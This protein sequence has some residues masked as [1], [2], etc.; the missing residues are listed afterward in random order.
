MTILGIEPTSGSAPAGP[1]SQDT[2][3]EMG[4]VTFPV[5]PAG[6]TYKWLPKGMARRYAACRL[7]VLD[8]ALDAEAAQPPLPAAR[9][10]AWSRLALILPYLLLHE[11]PRTIPTAPSASAGDR[12]GA[13]KVLQRRLVLAER[14]DFSSLLHEAV[15]N[16]SAAHLREVSAPLRDRSRPEVLAQAAARADDGCLRTAARLL[17]GDSVLPTSVATA[18]KVQ[19][20]YCTTESESLPH[21][22]RGAVTCVTPQQT[23][24]RVRNARGSAHP[25]PGGERNS[26]LHALLASPHAGKTLARWANAW[27]H[28]EASAAVRAP[29]LH[30]GLIPLDKGEGKARPIV[31]QEALLKVATGTVVDTCSQELRAAAGDWQHGVYNAGGAVQLV[32]ELRA[33][34]A[35]RPDQVMTGIDCRNAFGEVARR[36]ACRVAAQHCPTFARLLHNL[37]DGV[38]QVIHIPDGPGSTRPIL[39]HDGFVQGG[40]EAA[41]GFALSLRDAVDRFREAAVAAHRPCRIWA[42]MDDLYVQCAVEDWEPLMASLWDHL[43]TVNLQC[44]PTKSHCYVPAWTPAHASAMASE[45]SKYAALSAAGLPTLGTAAGGDYALFLGSDHQPDTATRTRLDKVIALCGYLRELCNA[46][47]TTN[48]RHPAWRMLDSVVNHALT[49][50]ASVND[51]DAMASHGQRLDEVVSDTASY[52]LSVDSFTATEEEQLRLSRLEGGCGLPRAAERAPTAFLASVLRLSAFLPV[53]SAAM[54]SHAPEF[55]PDSPAHAQRGGAFLR[56][57]VLIRQAGRAQDLLRACGLV[58]DQHGMPHLLSTPPARELDVTIDLAQPMPKRQRHWW[59]VLHHSRAQRLAT[60][61]AI[62]WLTSCGGPEGGAYLRAISAD[63]GGALTDNEFV[64]ATRFRMGM[65]VM[66]PGVCHHQKGGDQAKQRSTCFAP[67]DPHGHHAVTCKCGGA[68]YCAHSQGANVLLQASV[69]AGYQSRREQVVP[70]LA[71][72]KCQAPQ[73]DVEGW[74]TVGLSRLLIDFSI[75]H[76]GAARYSVGQDATVV[77]GREKQGHYGSR[78]GLLV[79]TAAMETYGRLGEECTELLDQLADLARQRDRRHGLPPTKWLHKW[80]AQL[81]LV[82]ARLVGRAIQQACPP[83]AASL[84]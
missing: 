19:A 63:G 28:V 5:H 44:Q 43:A 47:I 35:A 29:W 39:V 74:S 76:P 30:C 12:T 37:W 24:R 67:V 13:R 51:P 6:T 78:Q 32:W 26:H 18:D 46:P 25:G 56:Q 65:R 36:P 4:V 70:E 59:N 15:A 16:E 84:C 58:L 2:T 55:I 60:D 10:E 71:S 7:Q 1:S 64:Y 68:P 22:H 79:R 40:C 21:R 11:P 38:D 20:L 75:R 73:L 82:T 31:F 61:S 77:A 23:V 69:S 49:Y 3:W 17:T 81:S 66:S 9:V 14:G 42:Y 52:I 57:P 62:T 34:M 27:L 83:D 53:E 50:D 48:R 54:S 45:F 33:A 72:A 8:W 80:R 41:P